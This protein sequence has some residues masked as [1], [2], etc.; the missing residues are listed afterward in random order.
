MS[1]LTFALFGLTPL[2]G[3]GDSIGVVPALRMGGIA[4]VSIVGA[5]SH[6]IRAAVRSKRVATSDAGR[7]VS[8]R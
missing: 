1:M 6:A 8:S 7:R 3:L 2:G 5:R 4:I